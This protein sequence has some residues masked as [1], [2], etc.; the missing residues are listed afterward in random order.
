MV[1]MGRAGDVRGDVEA[2]VDA[3][4]RCGALVEQGHNPFVPR[5]MVAL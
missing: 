5:L 4:E 1:P 3:A 2:A